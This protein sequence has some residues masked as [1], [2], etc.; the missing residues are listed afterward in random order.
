MS[1]QAYC[2]DQSSYTCST[3]CFK[4]ARRIFSGTC[5][6]KIGE[7]ICTAFIGA[8]VTLTGKCQKLGGFLSYVS[9]SDNTTNC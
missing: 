2:T 1:Y 8:F 4:I 9:S 5:T 6:E 3:E 7:T